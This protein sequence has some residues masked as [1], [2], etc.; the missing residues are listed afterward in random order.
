MIVLV[1]D[2]VALIIMREDE[3]E[4][5]QHYP[6]HGGEKHQQVL[7]LQREE[8][9]VVEPVDED[10]QGDKDERVHHC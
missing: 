10:A 3:I 4:R 6:T 2:A 5:V 9:L 1:T 7:S 8:V